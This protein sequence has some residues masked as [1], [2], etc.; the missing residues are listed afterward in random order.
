MTVEA[1]A[2][3]ARQRTS[4]TVLDAERPAGGRD[5]LVERDPAAVGAV[6]A[7]IEGFAKGELPMAV[8]MAQSLQVIPVPG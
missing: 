2:A 5:Q 1:N 3:A 4:D 6:V 8:Y 7:G